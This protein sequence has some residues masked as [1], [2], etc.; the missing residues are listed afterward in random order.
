MDSRNRGKI[1]GYIS[2]FKRWKDEGRPLELIRNLPRRAGRPTPASTSLI[3]TAYIDENFEYVQEKPIGKGGFGKV[4]LVKKTSEPNLGKK[5]AF[6]SV[7]NQQNQVE[8]ERAIGN[9]LKGN[10]IYLAPFQYSIEKD[11][12]SIM[13]YDYHAG[14]DLKERL[15]G[16]PIE[17]FFGDDQLRTMM[18]EL[19]VGLKTLHQAGFVHCDIKLRN[20]MVD[21][22][23]HLVIIDFGSARKTAEMQSYSRARTIAYF[24]PELVDQLPVPEGCHCSQDWWALGVLFYELY[25]HLSLFWAPKQSAD[26]T[27]TNILQMKLPKL[28]DKPA[29]T[30]FKGLVNRDIQKRMQFVAKIEQQ[31]FFKGVDWSDV[32]QRKNKAPFDESE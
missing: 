12:E 16:L 22:D 25:E 9:A 21:N 8:I 13:V 3:N 19:V 28:E 26:V 31:D 24:S 11:D 32:K 20:I 17:Q 2:Q 6:K 4:Y 14:G 29:D 27:A 15:K 1:D 10:H 5:F 7:R 23:G 30:I 18:A